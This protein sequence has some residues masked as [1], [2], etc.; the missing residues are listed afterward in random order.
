MP[1]RSKAPNE[2]RWRDLTVSEQTSGANRAIYQSQTSGA[3][4]AIYQSQTR[5]NGKEKRTIPYCPASQLG[6]CAL[7]T[8]D[9]SAL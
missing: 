2:G 1:D 4:R 6:H 3:N 5:V 8:L 7:F 9:A